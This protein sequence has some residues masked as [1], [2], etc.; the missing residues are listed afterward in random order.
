MT[1]RA[2]KPTLTR[3][4]RAQMARNGLTREDVARALEISASNLDKILA[5]PESRLS[6]GRLR[7][8]AIVLE[9]TPAQL[10]GDN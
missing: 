9:T 3:N 2:A 8:L 10:M 1:K 5:A 4:I 7:V 6:V